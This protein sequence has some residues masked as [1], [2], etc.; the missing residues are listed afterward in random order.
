MS[1]ILTT[2]EIYTRKPNKVK[3]VIVTKQLSICILIKQIQAQKF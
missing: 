3:V 1:F 2:V